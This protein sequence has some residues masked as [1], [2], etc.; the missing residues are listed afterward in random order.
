[1]SFSF[2]GK[3]N[4]D[5]VAPDHTGKGRSWSLKKIKFV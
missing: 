2:Q 3:F 1:M 4:R 5:S